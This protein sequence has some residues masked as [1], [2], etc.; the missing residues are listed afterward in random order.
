MSLLITILTQMVSALLCLRGTNLKWG[1]TVLLQTVDAR[2]AQ[3]AED[4]ARRVLHHP[5]I[6]DSTLSKFQ[7]NLPFF[8][9]VLDRWTLASAIRSNEL[10]WILRKLSETQEQPAGAPQA[11]ETEQTRELVWRLADTAQQ[12]VGNLESLFN[13]VMDRASQRFVVHMRLWTVI[14]S[15]LMAF[16]LHL[17]AFR[18]LTQLSSDAELRASVV[19]ATATI[20]QQADKLLSTERSDLPSA[21][22][23]ELSQQAGVIRQSLNDARF[24][25]VPDPYPGWSFLSHWPRNRHFW[26]MLISAGL[27]SLG[28]PFWFNALKTLSNLRP[29]LASKQQKEQEPHTSS[30]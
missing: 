29:I 13:S 12:A 28:A 26:G 16:A 22:L 15:V 21:Q 11:P 18:L 1:L 9:K 30:T 10:V 20:T 19:M 3:H 7:D 25:L 14:F 5:L 4:I 6:S 8:T 23:Q 17:D 27:L 24:Q 2:L